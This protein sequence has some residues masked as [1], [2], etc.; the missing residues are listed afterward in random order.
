VVQREIEMPSAGKPA[1]H[2]DIFGPLAMGAKRSVSVFAFRVTGIG[3]PEIACA[4]GRNRRDALFVAPGG[5]DL[6][7]LS[8]EAVG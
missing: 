5:H 4:L 8:R 2:G 7:S 1:T 3:G 6:C